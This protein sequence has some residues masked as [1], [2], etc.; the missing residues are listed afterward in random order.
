MNRTYRVIE[1]FSGVGSQR[2][3]LERLAA[4]HPELK[5]EY[6]YQMDI[7]KYTVKSYNEIHGETPNLGDITKLDTLPDCDIFTWSFPC[8]DL[9]NAGLKRGMERESGT[10]SALCWEVIRLLTNSHRPE[11]LLMEN[12]PAILFKTN[13]PEFDKLCK[14]LEDLGYT[15]KYQVL[16]AVDF[17]IA[18][19]RKRCFMISHLNGDVP[20]FPE[21]RDLT[22]RLKDYL[23]DEVDQKYYLSEERLKGLI[24]SNERERKKGRGFNFEPFKM[25][26]ELSHTVTTREGCVKIANYI[27][28]REREYNIWLDHFKNSE[29]YRTLSG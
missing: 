27:L 10:R 9:S 2:M 8:Q 20:E 26:R 3:A 29:E 23:E 5:F 6:L 15:N 19:N 1:G 11:W 24:I 16:N 13:K 25:D 18:Q 4:K 12:V 28:E 21:K 14:A 7:D 17:D 22:H